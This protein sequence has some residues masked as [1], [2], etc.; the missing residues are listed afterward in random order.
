MQAFTTFMMDDIRS[1][2]LV[3]NFLFARLPYASSVMLNMDSDLQSV[4][5]LVRTSNP[6]RHNDHYFI[7][8]IK[9][10]SPE[11][12][13]FPFD[14]LI[15]HQATLATIDKDM[16][17]FTNLLVIPKNIF[18]E[19]R[20]FSILVLIG[21]KPHKIDFSRDTILTQDVTKEE[22]DLLLFPTSK[23]FA[24]SNLKITEV[25]QE[26]LSLLASQILEQRIDETNEKL[27]LYL[28]DRV[29][30]SKLDYETVFL[31]FRIL[32]AIMALK[33]IMI[34]LNSK[35]PLKGFKDYAP[36]STE[37]EIV[38]AFTFSLR[39]APV[40]PLQS[41]VIKHIGTLVSNPKQSFML[42]LFAFVANQQ[43]T[44]NMGTARSLMAL[45][46]F[47]QKDYHMQVFAAIQESVFEK[48]NSG[49][50][51]SIGEISMTIDVMIGWTSV[52]TSSMG[53]FWKGRLMNNLV[54]NGLMAFYL[55]SLKNSDPIG[56][57][58]PE[59]LAIGK[60]LFQDMKRFL[61]Q[62]LTF[63]TSCQ[64]L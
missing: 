30:L 40:N 36:L 61:N 49:W 58:T 9:K 29:L 6:M 57:P 43:S 52:K 27:V 54:A 17:K 25:S 63:A 44:E 4:P 12:N 60:P 38:E 14:N 23:S 34:D 3:K 22:D 55:K 2:D 21:N 31:G 51:L 33:G 35:R 48:V 20:V 16:L 37:L 5:D 18:L 56:N 8:Q 59:A 24:L 47:L 15:Y 64:K 10:E 45:K 46:D 28:W 53:R 11:K 50:D 19:Y 7:T 39:G 62:R 1:H 26:A 42:H 41:L 32:N 13:S